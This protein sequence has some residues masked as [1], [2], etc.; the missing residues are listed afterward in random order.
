[1]TLSIV[2]FYHLYFSYAEDSKTIVVNTTV[3]VLADENEPVVNESD[4]PKKLV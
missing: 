4:P 1:M 3:L 2:G